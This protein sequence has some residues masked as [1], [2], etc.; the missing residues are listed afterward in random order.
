M[1]TGE[2]DSSKGTDAMP[3]GIA[4]TDQLGAGSDARNTAHAWMP[5]LDCQSLA[6]RMFV[7]SEEQAMKN[8][9]QSLDK[10]AGRGG[11]SLAEAACLAAR[12]RYQPMSTHQALGVLADAYRGKFRAPNVGGEAHAPE[13]T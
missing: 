6:V 7:L 1:T 9:G 2:Q 10:L 11:L 3:V 12:I 5:L 8:H 13:R 4:S